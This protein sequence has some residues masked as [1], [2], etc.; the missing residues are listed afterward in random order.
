MKLHFKVKKSTT[1]ILVIK[2]N[3]L[4]NFESYSLA[5]LQAHIEIQ[6]LAHG[7]QVLSVIKI[8]RLMLFRKAILFLGIVRSLSFHSLGKK[9]NSLK[10]KQ[11]PRGL[12][13]LFKELN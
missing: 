2:T 6:C 9:Q 13:M 12:E 8:N 10:L 5:V 1:R 11:M 7:I 3:N 4:V